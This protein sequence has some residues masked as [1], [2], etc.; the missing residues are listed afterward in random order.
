MIP[1]TVSIPRPSSRTLRVTLIFLVGALLLSVGAAASANPGWGYPNDREPTVSPSLAS[2]PT[3]DGDPKAVEVGL[4][5][6]STRTGFVSGVRFYKVEANTGAHT[7]SLWSVD[8][9]RLATATFTDES[10]SGWQRV[11]FTPVSVEAGQRYVASY[12]APNGHYAQEMYAF[13]YGRTQD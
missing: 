12:F 4:E 3:D 10:E 6:I 5:F 7:G 13:G 9:K 11:S 1:R 2:S 8:G